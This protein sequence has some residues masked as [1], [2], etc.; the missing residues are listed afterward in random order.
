M[1][2]KTLFIEII[3]KEDLQT[4]WADE[5]S[6]LTFSP[7]E[8]NRSRLCGEIADYAALHGLLERMRDLNLRLVSLQVHETVNQS[9]DISGEES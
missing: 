3:L 2:L 5:F 6:E 9:P 8:D 4:V 7:T 1:R